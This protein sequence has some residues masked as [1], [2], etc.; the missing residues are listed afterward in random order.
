MGMEC[1]QGGELSKAMEKKKYYQ[2]LQESEQKDF[3]TWLDDQLVLPT[4]PNIDMDK[5]QEN[6]IK[7]M[8]K[9]TIKMQEYK[10]L[11]EEASEKV[12]ELRPRIDQLKPVIYG[13]YELHLE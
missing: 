9:H 11:E 3:E 1:V 12:K 4:N 7:A 10:L 8:E 6:L 13:R 2:E 5:R